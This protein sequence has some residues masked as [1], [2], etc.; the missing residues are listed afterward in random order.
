MFTSYE[1]SI[2]KAKLKA[3]VSSVRSEW[4]ENDF[5]ETETEQTA[6]RMQLKD[7]THMMS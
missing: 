2:Y 4:N 7:V 5:R 1:T 6:R 3:L